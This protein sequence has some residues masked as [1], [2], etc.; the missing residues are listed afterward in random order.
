[1]RHFSSSFVQKNYERTFRGCC[2]SYDP[3]DP[4]TSDLKRGTANRNVL[5]IK[6]GY[7]TGDFLTG[8]GKVKRYKVTS[9]RLNKKKQFKK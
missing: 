9:V 4:A 3:E 8:R 5:Q 6:D 2:C 1:V 7:L